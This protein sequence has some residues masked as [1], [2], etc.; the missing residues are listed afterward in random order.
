MFYQ[1]ALVHNFQTGFTYGFVI[2]RRECDVIPKLLNSIEAHGSY[3][4]QHPS[5]LFAV[6]S[7]LMIEFSVQ[8]FIR[9]DCKINSLEEVIGQHED[10]DRPRGNPLALDFLGTTRS[11]NYVTKKVGIDVCRLEAMLIAL[12]KIAEWKSEIEKNKW[13]GNEQFLV[14]LISRETHK[15][16]SI[17]DEK[18]VYLKDT[19]IHQLSDAKYQE[20]RISALIQVVRL[21]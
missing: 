8:R 19:C 4:C 2:A 17:V 18:I 1:V 14:S 10:H 13:S 3:G 5:L 6:A 11:I 9:Y 20:K 21:P 12:E 16:S 7:E 15:G